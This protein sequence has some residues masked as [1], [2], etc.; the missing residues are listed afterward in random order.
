MKIRDIISEAP[1]SYQQAYDAAKSIFSPAKAITNDPAYQAARDKTKNIF[2]PTKWGK[3]AAPAADASAAPAK[4]FEIKD[5][6]NNAA[7]G[8]VYQDDVKVLQQVYTGVKSGKIKPNVDAAALLP[9]LKAAY[10]T[11]PI[12]DDSKKLLAQFAQ[13]F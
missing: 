12:T 13:Q 6:L 2:S 8:K 11:Q 4:D 5:S 7:A 9:V 10:Q 1:G 3:S